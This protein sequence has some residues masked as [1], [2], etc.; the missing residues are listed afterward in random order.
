MWTIK[1]KTKWGEMMNYYAKTDIGKVRSKNQDQASIIVN[2]KDQIVAV[3]CDGMGGHRSGE[4]LRGGQC[5]FLRRGVQCGA[6]SEA[7]KNILIQVMGVY[8][9]G[10]YAFHGTGAFRRRNRFL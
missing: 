7:E 8:S 5:G 4:G 2:I 6:G 3:V 1:S 9:Y 10:R